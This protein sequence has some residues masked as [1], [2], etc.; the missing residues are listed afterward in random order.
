MNYM[1]RRFK[2]TDIFYIIMMIVPLC[3]GMFL[4]VITTPQ[5]EGISISGARIYFTLPFPVQNLPVTESQVNSVIVLV[6][7]FFLCL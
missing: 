7:L 4:K 2:L 5:S 6:V 3:F 1:T